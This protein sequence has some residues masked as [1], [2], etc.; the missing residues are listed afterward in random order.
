M[1]MMLARRLA[2]ASIA[3]LA[4]SCGL[5]LAQAGG[6]LPL[7]SVGDGLRWNQPQEVYT[8]VVPP[9]A[10]NT[11]VNLQVYSPALDLADYADGRATTGYYG[12][13]LYDRSAAF[14]TTFTLSGPNGVVLQR[15]YGTSREHAWESFVATALPAGTYTLSVTSKGNGK[16][17][18]AL[19]TAPGFSLQA[20]D[21]TVNARGVGTPLLAARLTVSSDWVGRTVQLSNYDGDGASEL[22]LELNLPNGTKRALS[23]SGDLALATDS[24]QVTPELVGEWVVYAFVQPATKQYSNAVTLRLRQGTESA[25]ARIPTFSPPAGVPLTRSLIVDVVDPQGRPIPGASYSVG[26]DN[27]VRPRLP[28]GFVPVSSSVL[29]GRGDVTSSTEVRLRDPAGRVRF[30]ARQPSGTLSVDVVATFG[31]SRVPLTGVPIEVGGRVQNAPFTLPLAPGDYTVNP[32]PLPGSNVAARPTRVTDSGNSRVT[33]EYAVRADVTLLTAPDVVE[34]CDV[35]QLT[36]LARTEFPFRL[37]ASVVMTLPVG[38]ETDYPLNLR[39]DLS[40][41]TPLRLR[42]PARVCRSDEA[43]ATLEGTALS[44]KG[45]ARVRNPTGANVTRAAL[46]ARARLA[47]TLVAVDGGYA[48]TLQITTE[49]VIDNLR[50]V[51][52]L[53]SGGTSPAVRGPLSLGGPGGQSLTPRAD[54]DTLLL[55]RL[56][57]GTYTLTYTLFTDLP[58][59][60][61]TTTPDLTW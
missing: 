47:K 32:T 24:I 46:G 54:G 13:E 57:A 26:N 33:I 25:L 39:G 50:V 42:V 31:T 55:G 8:L 6:E 21:F 11:P 3:F 28:E 45:N 49:G 52:P 59:D 34:A 27:V 12:D 7:V 5:A 43:E 10:A 38:W 44:A 35:T 30:V 9:E 20:S 18:F 37:P 53:P 61:A 60:R 58:P 51:D 4:V 19:R 48:V 41:A 1:N 56:E 17:A 22:K 2:T 29:E 16:N 14:E 23:V 15:T 36:A 40:A